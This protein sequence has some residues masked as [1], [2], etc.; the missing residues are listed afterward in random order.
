MKDLERLAAVLVCALVGSSCNLS[1]ALYQMG[2]P[3][4]GTDF[5]VTRAQ[6][7]GGFLEAT[8]AGAA[9]ALRIFA[10]PSEVCRQVLAP[11]ASVAFTM[12]GAGRL[13]RDDQV[14][15]AAGIGPLEELRARR[16]DPTSKTKSMIPRAQATY[17]V[18]YQDAE[19]TFLRGRFPLAGLVGWS[20]GNDSIAVVP[21]SQACDAVASRSVASLEYR[22]R[23]QSALVLVAEPSPCRIDALIRP[24]P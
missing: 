4:V 8:L 16:G 9:G 5:R 14:C 10:P 23:G 17:R 22:S 3:G 19:V 12:E 20:G 13:T 2:I 1:R 24:E 6:E 15:D 7:R 11:E 21:R 18:V